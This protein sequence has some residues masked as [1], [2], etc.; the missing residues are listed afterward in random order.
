MEAVLRPGSCREER[1]GFCLLDLMQNL[2]I[3]VK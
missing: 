3:N 2:E 1:D